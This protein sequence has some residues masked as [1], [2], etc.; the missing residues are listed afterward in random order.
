MRFFLFSE[1]ALATEEKRGSMDKNLFNPVVYKIIKA[2]QMFG[3]DMYYTVKTLLEK[4]KSISA[5]SRE[6]SISRKTVRKIRDKINSGDLKPPDQKRTKKLD[7]YQNLLDGYLE[8]GL[9]AKLIHQ[10]FVN[11]HHL[12]IGYSTVAE[13]IAE[14][15]Q[16]EI[17]IPVHTAP[18]EEAQVDFGY[19]GK[20]KKDGKWV[21]AWVF[22][23]VLSY[24]RYAYYE[25]V[26]DQKVKTFIW[27]H[28][29]AFEFFRG[30]PKTV[31]IDNLKSAVLKAN[32]Y[33]PVIQRQYSEFLTYYKSAPITARI[34]RGQDKGKVESGIKY[35]KNNF[36]KSIEHK[37]YYQ[38]SIDLDKWLNHVCNLRVHGTTR[39]VPKQV[40]E[41]TEQ[42]ELT[43]LPGKRFE[44]FKIEKR[45]VPS[46][47]HHITFNLSYYSVPSKYAG[48]NV[49]IQSN[50]K[51]LKVYK[52]F[53]QVALHPV[54]KEQGKYITKE[55][56]KPPYKQK[57][58]ENDYKEKAL[59]IGI[60]VYNFWLELKKEKPYHWHR[61]ISGIF[62]LRHYHDKSAINKACKRALDYRA[63]SYQ[64]VKNICEK[65][66]Y[67]QQYDP[68]LAVNNAKGFNND[69]AKYDS[70][71]WKTKSDENIKI[72]TN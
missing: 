28:I 69:L 17:Y 13:Y 63:F 66:L 55:D 33:E 58:S 51:I 42:K 23:M 20:Y 12:K 54:S 70:L 10:K 68:E 56:H 8:K 67:L 7:A 27:C 50:G 71:T 39:K 38:L 31:K 5:I 4:E 21:K 49:T 11:K 26:L 45:K 3:I 41:N 22:C 32:F 6:L 43:S 53:D 35:V 15:K 9:S 48:E 64:S 52:D 14:Y 61:F 16:S 29:H 65:K 40:Y 2:T 46:N 59:A 19:L 24:S 44:I 18:A 62:N 57:K 1:G 36:V 34:R 47:G 72:T 25:I 60:D 30:V 37:N